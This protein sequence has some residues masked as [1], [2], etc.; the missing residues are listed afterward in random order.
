[1]SVFVNIF[2]IFVAVCFN[3]ICKFVRV[4]CYE[5]RNKFSLFYLT[6][7]QDHL[8]KFI[9][10]N[11]G[12]IIFKRKFT[13]SYINTE[14]IQNMNVNKSNIYSYLHTPNPTL[15]ISV[16]Y[17]QVDLFQSNHFAHTCVLQSRPHEPNP[18]NRGIL[19]TRHASR[20]IS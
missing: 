2:S 19:F 8:I 11:E 13:K 14:K 10:A 17:T 9:L 5:T 7:N 20:Q 1:M 3:C 18:L 16:V 15:G 4:T 6:T 12:L